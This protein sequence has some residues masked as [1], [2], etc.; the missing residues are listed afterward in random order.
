MHREDPDV[1]QLRSR[2]WTSATLV[3]PEDVEAVPGMLNYWG[4]RMLYY[5]GL[6]FY[7][8]KGAIVELGPF[9]GGSTIC[10][11]APLAAR[12]F[13]KPIV[14]TYDL[15]TLSPFEREK[16][17]S[18]GAPPDNRTRHIFDAHLRAYIHLLRVYEGDILSFSWEAGPIEILFVDAA[19]SY[20]V[21]DHVVSSFFPALIPGRSIVVLQD[22]IFER[23][24][25][26]HHVVMEKLADYFD[27]VSDTDENSAIFALKEAIPAGALAEAQWEAIPAEEKGVL[28]EHAIERLDTDDKRAR[29]RGAQRIL[30]EGWDMESGARYH[31]IGAASARQ[32]VKTPSG[33]E[34]GSSR[35]VPLASTRGLDFSDFTILLSRQRSGTNAFRSALATHPDLFC[36][37]EVFNLGDKDSDN[38]FLRDTN[39]FNFLEAYSGA[40]LRRTL[41]DRHETL[42]LDFLEYLRCYSPK[43]HLIVD[44]KYNTLHFFTK[45]WADNAT[46]PYLLD[47]IVEHRL[48]VLHLTRMNYLR[49]GISTLKAWATGQY[50]VF[51][52]QERPDDQQVFVGPGWLTSLLERRSTEDAMITRRFKDYPLYRS[53]DY[54]QVFRAST[55]ELPPEV[56]RELAE[57]LDVPDA[58]G[59]ITDF[60]KQSSLPLSETISNYDEVVALLKDTQYAYCLVDE[61]LYRARQAQRV[62]GAAP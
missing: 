59:P 12:G 54:A 32:R 24:G 57:W 44:V 43:R 46:V 18:K 17:F 14:H 53:Y 5:L 3:L 58:F 19:K 38:E 56:R 33:D 21:F 30:Q 7:S 42:F 55:D 20:R 27:Y 36:F 41:P 9:L 62:A 49:Q 52:N 47:L 23:S 4:K 25:P 60:R 37:N 26:W 1:T 8:D 28:M 35:R 10:L 45:P 40:D 51:P 31:E 48:R 13:D 34:A 6:E 39:Y 50:S 15:F 22:Y 2:P 61:P 16:Y 11:A 29:V